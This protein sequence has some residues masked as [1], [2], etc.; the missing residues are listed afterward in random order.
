MNTRF[1]PLFS[2]R[3][4]HEYYG[5]GET[6]PDFDFV[7]AE[8]SREALAGTRL[9]P[10]L[11]DG[12]LY[13]LFEADEND[14]PIQ[15]ITGLELLVGLRL[16]NP[17]FE[18][19]SG[20]LPEPLPLYANS[21]SPH[22]LYAPQASDLTAGRFTPAA[23]MAERPLA[24]EIRRMKDKSLIW[25]AEIAA[26]DEVPSLDMHGWEAGCYLVTQRS[27]VKSEDRPLIVAP[28][29]ADAGVWGT[30]MIRIEQD[31]W[32]TPPDFQVEFPARKEILSYYVVAPENWGDFGKLSVTDATANPALNFRKFEKAGFPPDSISPALLGCANDQIALFR[33][34]AETPRSATPNRNIQLNR[35]GD[36]LVKNL[37]LPREDMPLARFVVRLSKP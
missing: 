35:N 17:Y 34:E 20:P 25:S 37:P 9:L 10:R 32:K 3:V 14:A 8:H 11:Y 7:L 6:C 13:V 12:K 5:A 21:A 22:A 1:L 23:A 16:R 2:L 19:F 26:G 29:L 33:S 36:T 27:G 18:Y 15:D 4:A 30:V 24:L 28:D 31:L